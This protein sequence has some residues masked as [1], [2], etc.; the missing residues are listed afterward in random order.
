MVPVPLLV[1]YLFHPARQSACGEH[2]ITIVIE[3]C[4]LGSFI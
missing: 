1:F 3:I 2:F 4:V